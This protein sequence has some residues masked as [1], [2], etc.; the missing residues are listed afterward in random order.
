MTTDLRVRSTELTDV[1]KTS[2]EETKVIGYIRVSTGAQAE[3]GISLEAQQYRLTSYA[4]TFD[5]YLV[6]VIVDAGVSAKSLERP[7]LQIALQR[8]R[9]GN[10]QA[11]LVAKLDRLTRSVKD[12]AK[13]LEDDFRDDSAGL[14]SVAENIDTT[15]A[16]G[17]L[18]LNVLVSVG[19]WERE[20]IGE[21]TRDALQH[22]RKEGVRLGKPSLGWRY[23]EQRDGSGRRILETVDEEQKA[24]DR[25]IEL[26]SEGL[27]I[28]A[29]SARLKTE[30]Y[31]TKQGKE[32]WS[33]ASIH[34]ALKR[35][36]HG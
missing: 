29:I 35:G 20:A 27:T 34:R 12:L 15:S 16:A 18:V 23:S 6:D 19:Q 33:T 31:R 32:E 2:V 7:G 17:R 5:L 14:I 4:Q 11:L 21:R 25:I 13:L 28:R 36:V 10:V 8:L 26:R 3:D 1:S 30:G 24:Y 22:L 9:S